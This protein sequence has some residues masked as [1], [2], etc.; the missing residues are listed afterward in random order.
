MDAS[1]SSASIKSMVHHQYKP[2]LLLAAVVLSVLGVSFYLVAQPSFPAPMSMDSF[3][4]SGPFASV[5]PMPTITWSSTSTV[6]TVSPG[7]TKTVIVTFVSSKNIRRA[8]VEISSELAQLVSAKPRSF[9]RI[10]QGQQ[11]TLTLVV[12]ASSSSP[13]GTASGSIQ[14]QGGRGD[15]DDHEADEDDRRESGKNLSPQ[16]KV[17]VNIWQGVRLV[18]ANLT[19]A[20]PP[21]WLVSST[22]IQINAVTPALQSLT[23]SQDAELPPADFLVRTFPNPN[24]VS[25]DD[26]AS[27]FDHGWFS[28]YALK[29]TPTVGGHAAIIYSDATSGIPHQPLLAAFIDDPAGNEVIVVTM[30][31]VSSGNIQDTF[32]QV[33]SAIQFN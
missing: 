13:L 12:T 31:L 25:I 8:D 27:Q 17:V 6:A 15:K 21:V 11:N 10:R 19:I 23:T 2:I 30:L 33:V 14:L 24:A 3:A 4:T 26:F 1:E 7:T 22:A 18:S 5:P 16:L 9:E 20:F 29:T 32:Q 28:T